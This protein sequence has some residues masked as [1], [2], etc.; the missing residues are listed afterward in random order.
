MHFP[1][2][3]L[4]CLEKRA[5][6]TCPL[7]LKGFLIEESDAEPVQETIRAEGNGERGAAMFFLVKTIDMLVTIY[8]WM[9]IIR[10]ILSWVSPYS[11]IPLALYLFRL[12]DPF[13]ER[14]RGL[15]PMP[16][17][18]FDLSPVIAVLLLELIRYI[19]VTALT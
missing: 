10:V 1:F 3:G 14:T 13:L 16:R 15:F 18:A 17:M 2:E 11:R 9:I 8:I 6:K 12:T 4:L 7:R 19:V 5:V